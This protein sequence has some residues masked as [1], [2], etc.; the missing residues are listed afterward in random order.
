[1]LF[2]VSDPLNRL[3]IMGDSGTQNTGHLIGATIQ[4]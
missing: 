1:M 3:F 4:K 2:K